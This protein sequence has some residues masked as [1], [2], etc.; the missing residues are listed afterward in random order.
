MK[1]LVIAFGIAA[2]QCFAQSSADPIS[3]GAKMLYNITKDDVIKSAEEMPEANY[4]FK[5]VATVRSFGE[6]VG[7]VADGQYEFCS[8][9]LGDSKKHPSIEKSKTTKADLVAALKEAISYC[10]RAYNGMTDAHAVDMVKFGP[11][12][13]S[14]ITI[15]NFNSGHNFEHYGNMIT[16]LRIKGLVP[17]SSQH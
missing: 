4:S 14:K 13:M 3:S 8:V 7:H 10:D 11:Y 16:Y 9:V 6:L 12:N 5:P 17:P 2:A 1:R 15:L